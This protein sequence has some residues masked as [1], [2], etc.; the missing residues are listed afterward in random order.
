[1]IAGVARTVGQ[2]LLWY[3][4]R[5]GQWLERC[6]H[7]GGE[8]RGG[9]QVPHFSPQ[10]TGG[11]HGEGSSP[12]LIIPVSTCRVKHWS[13]GS[14]DGWLFARLHRSN[15]VRQMLNTSRLTGRAGS[16]E[17]LNLY[18]VLPLNHAG[19]P[20]CPVTTSPPKQQRLLTHSLPYHP[21]STTC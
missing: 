11:L 13:L 7:G 5:P 2:G 21:A 1:M 20:H 10:H 18:R 4:S 8:G 17:T 3:A 14:R 6:H 16:H 12:R 15:G 19:G 9:E